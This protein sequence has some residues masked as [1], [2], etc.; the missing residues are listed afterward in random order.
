MGVTH[1]LTCKE[2]LIVSGVSILNFC[3]FRNLFSGFRSR[4]VLHLL[5]GLDASF[6][7]FSIA[8]FCISA[9]NASIII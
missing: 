1:W 9:C 4:V 8:C 7:T 2:G 3:D 6:W 5:L